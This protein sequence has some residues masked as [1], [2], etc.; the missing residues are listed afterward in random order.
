MGRTRHGVS[1]R[2]SKTSVNRSVRP[3]FRVWARSKWS[4]HTDTYSVYVGTNIA[5]PPKF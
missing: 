3:N 5:W 2:S 1:L 4:L